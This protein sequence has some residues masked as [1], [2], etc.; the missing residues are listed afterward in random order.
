MALAG[1]EAGA[2]I[3]VARRWP[4]EHLYVLTHHTPDRGRF[5]A[6]RMFGYS[7]RPNFRD[8]SGRFNHTSHGFRGR[9]FPL[10]KTPGTVR[11]AVMGASTIYGIYVDDEHTSSGLLKL[12]I[13]KAFP[14]RTVEVINGGVPGWTSA[15]TKRALSTRTLPLKPDVI[16]IADGRN[17][18]YP[19]LFNHY[20]EDY[21]H[22]RRQVD[23]QYSNYSHKI[24]FRYSHL[25][26][27][28]ATQGGG[29]LGFSQQEENPA[30]AVIDYRNAPSEEEVRQNSTDLT[31]TNAFRRN[32]EDAIRTAASQRVAVALST[33][34]FLPEK[35]A[36]G[37]LPRDPKT[38]PALARQ[39]NRN[40]EVIR[41]VARDL[42]TPLVDAAAL[43]TRRELLRDDCHFNTKGEQAYAG[44]IFEA[45]QPALTGKLLA[46]GE[47]SR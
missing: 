19:Q 24:L 6:D 11:V 32:L 3:W 21:S 10:E 9:E 26:L 33:I 13:E 2:R 41:N 36:S 40:N 39:A 34:P 23:F 5:T 25:F 22:Y 20:R 44:L 47:A 1:L 28:L 35:Y 31:R 43:L 45:I 7:L 46:N 30:Y 42:N 38:L 27:L 12:R 8:G 4:A 29:H 18:M 14:D 37:V 17:D 15:E 16:V